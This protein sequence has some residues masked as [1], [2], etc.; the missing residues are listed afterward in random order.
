VQ[1]KTDNRS[2]LG[3]PAKLDVIVMR[4][5]PTEPRCHVC[6]SPWRDVIEVLITL[7]RMPLRGIALIIPSEARIDHRS[8]SKHYQK[9]M[10]IESPRRPKRRP[11]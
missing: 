4:G 11:R 6:R 2:V 8:L 3:N 9:H 10:V 5:D 7:S 1:R